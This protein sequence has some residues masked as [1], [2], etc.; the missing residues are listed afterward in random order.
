[1]REYREMLSYKDVVLLPNYSEVYSRDDLST[2]IKF[3]D[4]TFKSPVIP[5][6]MFCTISYEKAEELSKE[7]YFYILHR[8]YPYD[9]PSGIESWIA[10]NHQKILISISIGVKDCDYN[11]LQRLAEENY[12]ID[13]VTIDVAHG[14]NKN[15][16]NICKFFH[17]LPWNKKPKL[18][19]GN[20]GS[21]EGAKDL[22]EWGADA[23]KVG[24]S[25]GFAC[26]TYNSTG[27]GTPMYS[28]LSE[29]KQHMHHGIIP[30]VPVIADGQIREIGDSCKAL[31]AGAKL[32]M[33]G[34]M[35]A[36]CEDSPAPV[37]QNGSESPN[38]VFFGSASAQNKGYDSYVEGRSAVLEMKNYSMLQLLKK[39]EQGIKSAMSY[40]GVNTP[41]L[42]SKMEARKRI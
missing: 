16:K 32:I 26:T 31:H 35:F 33:V 40:A 6:N 30:E 14:H 38:K 2:E 17:S 19:V 7:N 4:Y 12:S 37:V 15:V 39:F 28:I 20:V 29:I 25:M 42:I 41:Y 21:V 3:L 9:G 22:V 13:F 8:F 24:L 27:V 11:F 34:S 23:I 5:S 18:I 36:A 1:M 10:K